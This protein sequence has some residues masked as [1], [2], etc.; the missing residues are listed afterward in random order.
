[1]ASRTPQ[2]YAIAKI[3]RA[4]ERKV[5]ELACAA[6]RGS[7]LPMRSRRSDAG[8]VMIHLMRER[9]LWHPRA[10]LA[11]AEMGAVI[12]S[13]SCILREAKK[14]GAIGDKRCIGAGSSNP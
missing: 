3:N 2:L 10:M 5:L 6:S 4:N 9:P 14:L 12:A 1:M 8:G 7:I 11:A 13:R